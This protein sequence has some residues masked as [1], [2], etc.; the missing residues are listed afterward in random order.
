MKKIVFI[1][2]FI[3]TFLF[4]QQS[5]LKNMKVLSYTKKRDVVKYMKSVIAPELGVKCSFCHNM[6]DYASDEKSHKVVARQ[7]MAMTIEA[8]KTMKN[9]NFH[10]ISCWVCHKGNNHPQHP[11]KKK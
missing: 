8:N 6:T 9:L 4:G 11:P 2:G 10:E 1:L 3:F 7:M 5:E